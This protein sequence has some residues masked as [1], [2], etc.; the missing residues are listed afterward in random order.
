MK[1]ALIC[2][3]AQQYRFIYR[4]FSYKYYDRNISQVITVYDLCA[5]AVGSRF[6]RYAIYNFYVRQKEKVE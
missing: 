2:T 4:I 3:D 5:Y 6:D 1:H